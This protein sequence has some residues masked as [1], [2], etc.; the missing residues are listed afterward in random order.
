[1]LDRA[2]VLIAVA[3][4]TGVLVLAEGIVDRAH[5]AAERGISATGE[6]KQE[7]A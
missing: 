6:R 3:G 5:R 2:Q 7:P 4:V 1:M